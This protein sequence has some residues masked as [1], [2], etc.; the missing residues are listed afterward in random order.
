MRRVVAEPNMGENVLTIGGQADAVLRDAGRAL[1]VVHEPDWDGPGSLRLRGT[2]WEARYYL[3]PGFTPQQPSKTSP[4]EQRA[5]AGAWLFDM[6]AKKL[7]GQVAIELPGEM[8]IGEL[9]HHWREHGWNDRYVGLSP[10]TQELYEGFWNRYCLMDRGFVGL[11]VSHAGSREINEFR[12][13]VQKRVE[14]SYKLETA[15]RADRNMGPRKGRDPEGWPTTEKIMVMISSMFTHARRW[16][17]LRL[18]S[19]PTV[20]RAHPMRGGAVPRAAVET[21]EVDP[22]GFYEVELIRAV[23]LLAPCRRGDECLKRVLGAAAVSTMAWG[24]ARPSEAFT[25]TPAGIF[26]E[27]QRLWLVE[28]KRRRA[29]HAS[30]EKGR[31]TLLVGPVLDDLDHAISVRPGVRA[32]H[33]LLWLPA[34]FDRDDLRNWR[35]R[36]FASAAEAVG[37]D[38]TPK[39]LRHTYA[40]VCAAA[41]INDVLT[42]SE[43]GHSITVHRDKYVKPLTRYANEP[44]TGVPGA[45]AMIYEA[46]ERATR[47]VSDWLA[48]HGSLAG[49]ADDLSDELE[50]DRSGIAHRSDSDN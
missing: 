2:G 39:D 50:R 43:M 15:D 18:A 30:R 42:A 3:G 16:G 44:F 5:E 7:R 29:R 36:W 22:L 13:R 9:F 34:M 1:R 35:R 21:V 28:T 40:S 11:T 10:A 38:A 27:A 8:L 19:D 24:G 46:R 48:S 41:G 45:E 49:L 33:T 31:L 37:V 17:L 32:D 47:R 20:E 26:R 12:G 14:A 4:L 25:P 6:A 23:M